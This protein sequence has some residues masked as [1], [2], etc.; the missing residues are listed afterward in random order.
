ME[1]DGLD[2]AILHLKSHGVKN[3]DLLKCMKMQ[4][5]CELVCKT[6]F[7][8]FR[9]LKKHM[10]EN[11]CMILCS[12]TQND[13]GNEQEWNL[14]DEFSDLC[15]EEEENGENSADEN[16]GCFGNFTSFIESFIEK[17][18]GFN[19]Q[20]DVQNDILQ[21]S[22]ELIYRSTDVSKQIIKNNPEEDVEIILNSTNDFVASH[23]DTFIS[24]YKRDLHHKK[25]QYFVAP[26]VLHVGNTKINETL[27]YVPIRKTLTS[28]FSNENFK[29]EYFDYNNSHQCTD[30]IYERFC[31]GIN[32]KNNKLFQSNKNAIQIQ[33]FIDDFQI[34]SPLK[35]RTHKVCAIYFIVHNFSPK[36]VSQ[37]KNMYLIS[38]CNSKV[39]AD[40]GCNAILEQLVY[41]LKCLEI[42]GISIN[43]NELT[44]KGTLV[45]VTFDNLGGNEIFGFVKCFSATYYCRICFLSKQKCQK[46]TEEI[47]EKLRTK[48]QYDIEM[49]KIRNLPV[50]KVKTDFKDSFGYK[51]YCA[52]NDLNYFHS[53]NNR[54]QDIMHD[55]YEGAMPFTLHNFFDYLCSHEIIT[56]DEIAKKILLF[57]Y[58]T[59]ERRNVPSPVFLKRANLNQ[60]ASQ[61]HCLTK[62]IPFIFADLLSLKDI[63]KR[64]HVHKAWKVI[65]YLLKI[66]QIISSTVI[67]EA[68][69]VN[70]ENFTTEFLKYTKTIFDVDFIPK[71]HF[72]THYSNTI[73]AMGPIIKL[74]MMRGDGKHQTFTRYAKRTNNFINI[75]KTL[76]EKHQIE[77]ISNLRENQFT[78]NIKTNKKNMKLVDKDGQ[79]LNEFVNQANSFSERFEDIHEV[80]IKDYLN[81]NSFHFK[82]GLFVIFSN[83]ICQI[84][85]I[86]E[87]KKT[88]Y[89][90]C[91]H[92]HAVKFRDFANSIEIK[93]STDTS[94]I[95]FSELECKRS[96]EAKLLNDKIQI[97]ADNL[98]MFPIYENLNK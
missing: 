88:F 90:L 70:L 66:N 2:G 10:L 23:I 36:F 20:H 15:V 67:K 6:T 40:N 87:S 56:K 69:L 59:L 96:Y 86:F 45:Q 53:I 92:F 8:S 18:N 33:I 29:K 41:D 52:L 73:R 35:T 95:R 57:D 93:K 63:K 17:L 31:C 22:K 50:S 28:L 71:L 76:T 30:G 58:G 61:M 5:S 32:F 75:C 78:D 34:T 68:D 55:V 54:S 16:I 64:K 85:F 3:G 80:V 98:D 39:V 77:M 27:H 37:L 38:L 46:C 49:E 60:N 14:L 91:T 43:N 24:R 25:S 81:V 44:L 12:D 82:K 11:K 9:A 26:R 65:E 72:M 19:L 83:Q 47:A 13:S 89:F 94:L 79:L 48:E 7:Q 4:I 84:D 51:N 62:H 42:E 74:Q 97:I 1:L 21:L